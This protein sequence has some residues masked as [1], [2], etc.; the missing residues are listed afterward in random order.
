VRL[1]EAEACGGKVSVMTL[2]A[3]YQAESDLAVALELQADLT[4][5]Q[6]RP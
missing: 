6:P 5:P 1:S 2:G 3:L 4:Q